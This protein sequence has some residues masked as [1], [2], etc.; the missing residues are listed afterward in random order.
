MLQ[1]MVIVTKVPFVTTPAHIIIS[2]RSRSQTPKETQLVNVDTK[3]P[4]KVDKIFV[5]HPLDLGGRGIDPL[6]PPGPL[7]PSRYFGLPMMNLCKPP[8]PPN[9]PYCRPFNYHEYVKDYDPN[10]HVT[11]F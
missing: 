6:K 9:M 11:V 2:M 10:A 8:L 1:S 3:M 7:R 5:G 4:K